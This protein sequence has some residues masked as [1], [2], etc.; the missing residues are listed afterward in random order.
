MQPAHIPIEEIDRNPVGCDDLCGSTHKRMPAICRKDYR[1]CHWRFQKGVEVREAFNVQHV[2]LD[3]CQLAAHAHLW[4]RKMRSDLINEDD[5]RDDLCDALVHITLHDLVY[6]FP[7]LLRNFRTTTFDETPHNTH[8]VLSTLRPCVC[9]I[10]V[11]QC[12]VLHKLFPL[13]NVALR[14]RNVCFRLQVE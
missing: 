2:H 13:V 6:F 3:V 5:T 4:T 11:A 9:C 8:D 14:Q 1:W 10:K 12:H 7:Q